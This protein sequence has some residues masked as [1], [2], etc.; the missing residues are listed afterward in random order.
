MEASRSGKERLP[1]TQALGQAVEKVRRDSKMGGQSGPI[2]RDDILD[3]GF[4]AD[5]AGRAH[6]RPAPE[7][8]G[9]FMRGRL[10]RGQQNVGPKIAGGARIFRPLERD[11]ILAPFE[12]PLSEKEAR[13]KL[14][15]IAGSPHRGDE[16]GGW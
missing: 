4:A 6:D 13:R 9:P 5:A 12:D 11:E 15:V 10:E 8:G 14:L 16:G 3:G 2:G 1:L 7:P